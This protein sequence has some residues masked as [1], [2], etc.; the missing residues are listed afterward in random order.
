MKSKFLVFIFL[1]L[2]AGCDS[3]SVRPSNRPILP[4][5]PTSWG[6]LLGQPHWRYEWID[7]GGVW[8][9]WEGGP[10]TE[11]PEFS[12]PDEWTTPVLAWPFW[13]EWKL[14]PGM[15]RPAGALFP[16]DAAGGKIELSWIGGVEAFFWKELAAADRTTKAAEGRLPWYFDWMRFKE[17]LESADIS[18]SVRGDPWLAD[19]KEIGRKTVKSGFDRRRIVGRKFSEVVIP[20]LGGRWVGNSPFEPALEAP[21]EGP[22]TLQAADTPGVWV[23][24]KGILK[25]S[26][27]GW[28]L[29]PRK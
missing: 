10:G 2:L 11:P 3:S 22:L 17:L 23:S 14:S 25:C 12:P 21:E 4:V 26:T 24:P 20:E 18:E 16:W 15:M 28:V 13:P 8:Q 5:L 27:S 1:V 9:T 7:S 6:D 19:W 29:I